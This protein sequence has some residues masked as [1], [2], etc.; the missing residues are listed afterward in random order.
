MVSYTK[1]RVLLA[2]KGLKWKNLKEDLGINSTAVAKI[3][4][5]QYVSLE[6]LERICLYF[7]CQLNDIC[8]IKKD[9]GK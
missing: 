9:P 5:D 6:V 1:L 4:K 3:N 7:D 2:E 8:T